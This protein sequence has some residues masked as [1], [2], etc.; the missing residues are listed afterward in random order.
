MLGLSIETI[1][2]LDLRQINIFLWDFFLSYPLR[3]PQCIAK[4]SNAIS[5]IEDILMRNFEY[6]LIVY[7]M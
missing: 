4:S 6:L 7:Y 5:S 3:I 2:L 1:S